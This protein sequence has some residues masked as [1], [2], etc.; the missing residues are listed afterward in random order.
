MYYFELLFYRGVNRRRSNK[1]SGTPGWIYIGCWKIIQ[2][3]IIIGK[4]V[5]LSCW[6][7]VARLL[8]S[9]KNKM[10]TTTQLATA[11]A[12]HS[13]K[14]ERAEKVIQNY[15]V[16]TGA[17]GVIPIPLLD[18]AAV[19]GLQVKMLQEIGLIYDQ[20][21]SE[22]WV[23]STIGALTAGS[24]AMSVSKSFGLSVVGA[25]PFIGGLAKLLLA[26]GVAAAS[27]YALG[28]IFIIHFESGSSFLS[29]DPQKY[30]T[31]MAILM[32][33]NTA[34]AKAQALATAAATPAASTP[35]APKDD[36]AKK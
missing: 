17:A 3:G 12:G 19:A 26:P 13:E 4:K 20:K 29:L 27:T 33:K 15:L 22:H 11:H 32:A 7:V 14:T 25:V 28:R 35:A 34:E 16:W 18:T 9:K 6:V 31:H 2:A 8:L 24:V 1:Q 10:E 21:L 23:K 5:N 36:A 30:K